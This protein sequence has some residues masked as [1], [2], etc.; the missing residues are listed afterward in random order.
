MQATKTNLLVFIHPIILSDSAKD[1]SDLRR[2]LQSNSWTFSRQY[3]EGAMESIFLLQRDLPVLHEL[4]GTGNTETVLSE[5]EG[6]D[7]E[8]NLTVE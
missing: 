8:N 7:N 5:P 4:S 1:Q 2:A 3:N 6:T